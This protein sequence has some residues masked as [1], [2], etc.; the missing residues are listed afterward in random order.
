MRLTAPAPSMHFMRILA[1]QG[2]DRA[3]HVRGAQLP[4]QHY[5]ASEQSNSRGFGL[6]RPAPRSST[7]HF[8][9]SRFVSWALPR[10]RFPAATTIPGVESAER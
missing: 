6:V 4:L 3:G 8:R 5:S 2:I 9:L 7:A 10:P 1:R